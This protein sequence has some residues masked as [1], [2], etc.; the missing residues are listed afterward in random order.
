MAVVAAAAY[1]A[2]VRLVHPSDGVLPPLLSA[3]L[4]LIN[5][6]ILGLLVSFRTKVAYDRWWEGR[7]LWGQLV[8]TSRNLCLK[9]RE[10]AR[11]DTDERLKFLALIS[12]F[13]FALMRHLRGEVQLTDIPNFE[14]DPA[15]PAHVP[16]EIARRTIAMVAGLREAGRID[17]HMHQM[18][19]L[20]TSALMDICGA[21]ERIRNTP[22]ASSYLSLLRHGLVLGFVFTPWALV[23]T[24]G[25]WVIPVQAVAVYFLFGIELT[26][27]AVEQPFGF[28]GDDL[29]LEAYCETIR[30][31]AEDILR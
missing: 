12:A 3:Q 25:L 5:T 16:A 14:K 6:A 28:D 1:S 2:G 23:Q 29:P 26:A 22:L 19:D 21:C 8:N 20:H 4:A 31:S 9:A 11:L 30:A 18:L 7:L 13:P 10:L 17:G 24:L 15:T 27:E